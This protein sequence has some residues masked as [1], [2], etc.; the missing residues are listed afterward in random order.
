MKRRDFLKLSAAL[1]L[2]GAAAA[3]GV[4]VPTLRDVAALVKGTGKNTPATVKYYDIEAAG[5]RS[6]RI[7]NLIPIY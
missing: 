2:T 5:F 4:G 1:A 3:C 7:E 6:F